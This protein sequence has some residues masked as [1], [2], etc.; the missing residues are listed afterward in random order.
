MIF[1]LHDVHGYEHHEIAE[2]L[3]CTVGNTKSQL[4]KASKARPEN[5]CLRSTPADVNN[6]IEASGALSFQPRRAGRR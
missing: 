2:F 5:R 4:H 3:G 1:M 6:V